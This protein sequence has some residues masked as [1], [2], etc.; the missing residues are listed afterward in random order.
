MAKHDSPLGVKLIAHHKKM[1]AAAATAA[2]AEEEEEEEAEEGTGPPAGPVDTL[3]DTLPE[4]VRLDER[5][6]GYVAH[7][8]HGGDEH[9]VGPFFEKTDAAAAAAAFAQEPAAC[10]DVLTAWNE[11]LRSASR[12]A[13]AH[14]TAAQIEAVAAA[15]RGACAGG[16]Y[17]AHAIVRRRLCTHCFSS[18]RGRAWL[19]EWSGVPAAKAAAANRSQWC[20]E[21][22]VREPLDYARHVCIACKVP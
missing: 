7:V 2:E 22:A 20:R 12:A 3:P 11:D 15:A 9:I 10:V 16:A 19:R 4:G 6:G 14:S 8:H 21:R 5:R 17:T 18:P 13:L 1:R